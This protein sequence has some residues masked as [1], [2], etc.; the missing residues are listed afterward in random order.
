MVDHLFFLF[1]LN[2]N[3]LNILL[4]LE[5]SKLDTLPQIWS[6]VSV[7]GNNDFPQIAEGMSL[8]IQSCIQSAFI[9]EEYTAHLYSTFCFP[10]TVSVQALEMGQQGE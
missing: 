3:S 2:Q 7:R 10:C 4:T 5:N 6:K 9:P 1:S 8:L